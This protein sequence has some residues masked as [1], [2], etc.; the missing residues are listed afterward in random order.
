[1][2]GSVTLTGA[3]EDSLGVP[4]AQIMPLLDISN[5][6]RKTYKGGFLCQLTAGRRLEVRIQARAPQG[7]FS[8]FLAGM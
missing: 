8:T 2:A 5:E 7:Q 1:M 3:F 4:T 6:Q